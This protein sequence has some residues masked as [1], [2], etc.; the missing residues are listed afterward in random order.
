M[1]S[2][3]DF[4]TAY[5]SSPRSYSTRSFVSRT[6]SAQMVRPFLRWMTSALAG[7]ADNST[8]MKTRT[9]T[10]VILATTRRGRKVTKVLQLG[11]RMSALAGFLAATAWAQA[12]VP[13]PSCPQ[14]SGDLYTR[15]RSVELDPQRVYRIRD[16]SIDRPNLHPDLHA[17]TVAFTKDICRT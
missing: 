13:T 4:G 12:P 14:T 15:V 16:A 5:V 7:S 11:W 17:G 1:W 8:K 9:R 6:W 3:E 2:T 10:R